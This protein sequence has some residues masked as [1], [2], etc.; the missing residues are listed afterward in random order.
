MT[1]QQFVASFGAAMH[2]PNVY[3]QWINAGTD[4]RKLNPNGAYLKHLSLRTIDKTYG[5]L[6]GHADYDWIHANHPEWILRDANGNTVPM[7]R[8]SEES[9]DFGNPAYLDWVF[10]TYFPNGYFDST[11][12][13]P[14][15]VTWYEQDNGDFLR[16]HI[17]CAA[18]DAVC[19]KYNTD[20][21]VQ[22]AWKTL[23]DKFHQYYPSK[24]VLVSSTTLSYMTPAT[25]LAFMEDVLSHS[26][27]YY[28][29]CLVNDLC[30]WNSQPNNDK[31]NALNAT[32]Q[33]ADWCAAKGKYF[34]P[35]LGQ[36]AV[37][38]PTQAQFNYGYAF[39]NL[40]RQGDK[41]FF[42]FILINSSGQ[43]QPR[44]IPEMTLPLGNALETRQQI[45][46]NVYRRSFTQG[47][48]YVNLSDSQVSIPLPA[49]TY[50]NSLGQAV[51]SPLILSS[52]SG[53]T[54]CGSNS[55][56]PSP[57]QTPTPTPTPSPTP[58]QTPTPTPTLSPTPSSTPTP[59]PSPTSSPTATVTPTATPTPTTTA[60]PT[61]TAFPTVTPT[62]T[63]TPSATATPTPSES[64][65]PTPSPAPTVVVT[66]PPSAT[67]SPTPATPTPTP[68]ATA[69]SYPPA[70]ATPTAWPTSTPTPSATASP[71]LKRGK[72]R[73]PRPQSTA[74]P[75][76]SQDVTM[77][78]VS[79]LF[80]QP[81]TDLIRLKSGSDGT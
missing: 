62:V 8:S 34:F 61:P 6:E 28:S 46:P 26:D 1:A 7:Y 65:T 41:Q 79:D 31:R 4:I 27:G 44:V 63:S 14:N 67:P 66:P 73:K 10:G 38:Q 12:R 52:F 29:E 48:A 70:S 64:P 13:D 5:Y 32:L 80:G 23:L 24:K 74:S 72:R 39:F 60:T 18:D 42:S 17:N 15:L 75:S 36:S 58:T 55:P 54:V 9:L 19:Q 53:L 71:T 37:A 40:L 81:R 69:F 30:Y 57:S 56:S 35:V 51:N 25:Q 76:S 43:W 45:S 21:G 49:G 20:S 50:K 3:Q 22:T 11:D 16:M 33:L 77:S 68:S 59:T 47:I 2:N 78:S